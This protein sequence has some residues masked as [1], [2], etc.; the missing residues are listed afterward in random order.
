MFVFM[1]VLKLRCNSVV[2]TSSLGLTCWLFSFDLSII[3]YKLIL[4]F[5]KYLNKVVTIAFTI[6]LKV[7]SPIGDWPASNFACCSPKN[8]AELQSYQTFVLRSHELQRIALLRHPSIFSRIIWA[9]LY[10]YMVPR[11]IKKKKKLRFIPIR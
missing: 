5:L 9:I 3:Q 4:I 1:S 6:L 11:N 10:L 8:C 7:T 2:G